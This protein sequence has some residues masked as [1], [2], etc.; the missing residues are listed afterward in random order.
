MRSPRGSRAS[1]A[2]GAAPPSRWA[3]RTARHAE[4]P[5]LVR[6]EP[7]DCPAQPGP[8][9]T[10]GGR[11]PRQCAAPW[12]C[13]YFLPDP[14]GHGALRGVSLVPVTVEDFAALALPP[15][16]AEASSVGAL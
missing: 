14:H 1:T 9:P 16:F 5:A 3:D 10:G 2:A 13:L 7:G 4:H 8:S 6:S 15:S 12:H 11:S